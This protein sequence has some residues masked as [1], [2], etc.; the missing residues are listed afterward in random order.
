M[1]EQFERKLEG[2]ADAI[3]VRVMA[4]MDDSEEGEKLFLQWADEFSGYKPHNTELW[5][6]LSTHINWPI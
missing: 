4:K 3:I 1:I 5:K 6:Q 2:I